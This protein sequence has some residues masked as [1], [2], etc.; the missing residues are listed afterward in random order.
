MSDQE[1]YD[2]NDEEEVQEEDKLDNVE[3]EEEQQNEDSKK[4]K[5]GEEEK[6]EEE[7]E[8]EVRSTVYKS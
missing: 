2:L 8:E 7:D 3:G 1:D 6:L 4:D 5:E